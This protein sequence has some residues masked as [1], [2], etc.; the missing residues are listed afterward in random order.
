MVLLSLSARFPR[1]H[2]F[3][4]KAQ[5]RKAPAFC[6]VLAGAHPGGRIESA[7][8]VRGEAKDPTAAEVP[9]TGS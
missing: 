3:T 5:P 4:E 2:Q 8:Q 1:T 9:A 6:R 7:E